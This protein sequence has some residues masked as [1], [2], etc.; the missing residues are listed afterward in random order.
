MVKTVF[1]VFILALA[2]LSASYGQI[3]ITSGELPQQIG[4]YGIY[5][6]C[7]D[8]TVD[9]GN[10]GGGN[11]WDFTSQVTDQTWNWWIV[12]KSN[13]PFA[14]LF[15]TAN[16]VQKLA[17]TLS[18]LYIYSELTTSAL[19]T[20]GTGVTTIVGDQV[21]VYEDPLIIPLPISYGD[22][23]TWSNTTHDTIPGV[24]MVIVTELSQHYHVDAWGTIHIP[25]GTV[26]CLRVISFDT[27]KSI[28]YFMGAPWYGD[29]TS[30]IL[31]NFVAETYGYVATV[32]SYDDETDPN[33][34]EAAN[35]RR[36]S[37]FTNGIAEDELIDDYVLYNY[38][39]PFMT[40]TEIQFTL[41][42][43]QYVILEIFNLTGEKVETLI[44]GWQTSG[45]KFIRWDA[46]NL[47]G[48]VYLYRIETEDKT[49]TSK[50]ILLR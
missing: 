36:L 8:V 34:T 41:P 23:W 1:V 13:T 24:D 38:P 10:T 30:N 16:Y 25:V 5:Q 37:Y 47:P 45:K 35:L 18:A 2:M 49:M 20:L 46:D 43:D 28:T 11:T 39:D 21:Y 3:S 33:F 32:T 42:T 22:S 6:G 48:G 15:P 4:T 44:D 50:A 17:D 7:D 40:S 31:Y 29:T 14:D 9:V 26:N 19:T 12:N 27:T